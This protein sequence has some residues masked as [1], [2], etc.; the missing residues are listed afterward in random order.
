VLAT[1]ID[2][3]D[4]LGVQVYD[5][6]GGEPLIHPGIASLVRHVKSKRGHS[7][8]V[9]IITN[10]FLLTTEGI[11][12]LNEAGLDFMQVSVDSVSPTPLSKKS[13]KSVLPRLRLLAR[14]PSFKVEVQTV[15]NDENCT[16]MPSRRSRISF[17][18]GFRSCTRAPVAIRGRSSSPAS[19]RTRRELTSSTKE[20][21]LGDF[22]P[23]KCQSG[24]SPF[25][26]LA[27]CSGG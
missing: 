18:F 15:L 9:T 10:G 25:G 19:L 6:L 26:S 7:N 4:E 14:E 16:P 13:L 5:L 8:L 1:R 22:P 27:R 11:N 2:T 20:M 17:D 3:L 21:L 23:W 12:A 24:F